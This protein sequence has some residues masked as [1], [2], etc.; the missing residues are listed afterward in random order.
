LVTTALLPESGPQ[1]V[2]FTSQALQV[3]KE[4]GPVHQYGECSLF[5]VRTVVKVVVEAGVHVSGSVVNL[6]TQ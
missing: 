3:T 5:V 6:T 2:Q 1:K 4:S